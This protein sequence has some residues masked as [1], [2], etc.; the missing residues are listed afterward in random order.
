M[1]RYQGRVGN[2]GLEALK[3]ELLAPARSER[4]LVTIAHEDAAQLADVP[5]LVRSRKEQRARKFTYVTE[6]EADRDGAPCACGTEP[7]AVCGIHA[8]LGHR[9]SLRPD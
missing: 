8:R 6:T 5:K 9:R 3:R 7:G 1:T 4:D 2:V